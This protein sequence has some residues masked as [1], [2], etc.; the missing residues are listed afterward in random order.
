MLLCISTIFLSNIISGIFY[1]VGKTISVESRLHLFTFSTIT[2]SVFQYVI[3]RHVRNHSVSLFQQGSQTKIIYSGITI[4]QYFFVLCIIIL[5]LQ[6]FT[7]SEY[8][9]IFVVLITFV[10]YISSSV[11]I[12]V[13]SIKLLYWVQRKRNKIFILYA[14]S[15]IIL[16]I[17]ILSSV[18]YGQA[19]FLNQHPVDTI[20][21]R[22]MIDDK[23]IP[24]NRIIFNIYSY[25]S[26]A[27][28]IAN[29]AA[30]M[31]LLKSYVQKSK[32][33]Y[34]IVVSIPLFYF[35][36]QYTSLNYLVL[37]ELLV[38]LSDVV[39]FYNIINIIIESLA[40]ALIG[41]SFFITATRISNINLKYNLYFCAIGYTLLFSANYIINVSSPIFP[42]FGLVGIFY[43]PLSTY[44]IFVGIYSAASIS[45]N[46]TEL[47]TFIR[48]T[49]RD[50]VL[51]NVG[52]SEVEGRIL[53]ATKKIS[54]RLE[55]ETGFTP[56]FEDEDV[57]EY[58][59]I[60]STELARA[61]KQRN[62]SLE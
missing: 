46:D 53:K 13:L 34:W 4:I 5:I 30:A 59:K 14:V 55:K 21:D 26:I 52:R 19:W 27:S 29:F 28:F 22:L 24:Q 47:R 8:S 31:M 56:S 1:F 61:K 40:G 37:K 33:F 62:H 23:H 17:N 38:N 18:V 3:L 54:N 44:L 48:K 60:V 10:G 50:S 36:S 49:I 43:L 15:L 58:V 11:I 25:S 42:P 9:L 2:Y 45:A 51:E 6:M 20:R 12:S 41:I 7:S 32:I 16:T 39:L 35:V 57:K